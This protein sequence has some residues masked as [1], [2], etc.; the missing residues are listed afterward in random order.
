[1]G[2][3]R[4]ADE[5]DWKGLKAAPTIHYVL[6]TGSRSVVLRTGAVKGSEGCLIRFASQ[7]ILAYK[8]NEYYGIY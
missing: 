2:S 5:L 7:I 1:V 8:N 4:V 6:Q 3:M